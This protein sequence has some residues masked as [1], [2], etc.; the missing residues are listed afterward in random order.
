ME[1]LNRDE[2][3]SDDHREADFDGDDDF[4]FGGKGLPHLKKV[5]ELLTP[6]V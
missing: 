3:R 1:I 6:V 5:L 4:E 2:E